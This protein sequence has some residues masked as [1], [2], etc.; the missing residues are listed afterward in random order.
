MSPPQTRSRSAELAEF[1]TISVK[2][3]TTGKRKS[4]KA[5]K[6]LPQK[7]PKVQR[8]KDSASKPN[9]A[10][11]YDDFGED[12]DSV[13]LQALDVINNGAARS[14]SGIEIPLQQR[15]PLRNSKQK[16]RKVEPAPTRDLPNAT[17]HSSPSNKSDDTI[18]VRLL[19]TIPEAVG[20]G[21]EGQRRPELEDEAENE[22]PPSHRGEDGENREV[23]SEEGREGTGIDIWDLTRKPQQDDADDASDS[24]LFVDQHKDWSLSPEP[25][26]SATKSEATINGLP[27]QRRPRRIPVPQPGVEQ[28]S[29]LAY[30]DERAWPATSPTPIR[31][32][33][34]NQS[35]P[36]MRSRDIGRRD[37]ASLIIEDDEDAGPNISLS[38]RAPSTSEV[39]VTVEVSSS[40]IIRIRSLM[41]KEGWTNM[42]DKW[43]ATL[44][45]STEPGKDTPAT[46]RLGEKCFKQMVFLKKTVGDGYPGQFIVEQ[47]NWLRTADKKLNK[48]MEEIE[49]VIDVICGD[50]LAV[51][52]DSARDGQTN[53]NLEVRQ[54][55]TSDL[56]KSIIPMLAL[57]LWSLFA[58][59]GKELGPNGHPQL[60]TEGVFTSSILKYM[61]KV[62]AWI[63][64]LDRVLMLE[65]QKRPLEQVIEGRE[66]TRQTIRRNRKMLRDLLDEWKDTLAEACREHYELVA[67]E[68]NRHEA[69]ERDRALK[70]AKDRAEEDELA[71][72]DQQWA[73]MALSTQQIKGQLPLNKVKWEKS[74]SGLLP[75]SSRVSKGKGIAVDRRLWAPDDEKYLLRQL[76]LRNRELDLDDLEEIHDMLDYPVEDIRRKIE[77][78]KQSARSLSWERGLLVENWAV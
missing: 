47:N 73:A 53:A 40:C 59:G 36:N 21:S 41:G 31:W 64:R 49:K 27:L 69:M 78:L 71:R 56:A 39:Q 20:A 52:G 12:A 1:D 11:V 57:V 25:Q 74:S 50:R 18:R 5:T 8:P 76:R 48:S 55:L 22:Q 42:G 33:S 32:L 37:D 6:T 35:S 4:T 28:S 45:N 2:P 75:P 44:L 3:R 54:A 60:L 26:S 72:A 77:A 19:E 63:S 34:D 61:R 29:P 43:S 13:D 9:A 23:A 51:I 14:R 68:N 65:L 17:H 15:R 7:K 66:K 58:L 24:D 62:T 30:R 38:I 67:G 46:T 70:E 16:E 10:D